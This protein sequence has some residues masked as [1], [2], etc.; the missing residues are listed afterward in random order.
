MSDDEMLDIERAIILDEENPIKNI[1]VKKKEIP[2]TN[3]LEGYIYGCS[4]G[5][6]VISAA[7][8]KIKIS[9]EILGNVRGL[10]PE[11]SPFNESEYIEYSIENYFIRSAGLY[12]RCLMFTG[13]VLNLGIA[14]ESI[15]HVLLVTN[16]HVKDNNLS[17][18]LKKIGKACREFST[19][20]NRIIHHGRYNDD[21]FTTVSVMHKANQLSASAGMDLPFTQAVIDH[22]TDKAIE[23]K[24][25]DFNDHLKKIEKTVSD[26]YDVALPVY[27]E[28]KKKLLRL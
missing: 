5:L 28:M 24:T 3:E 27:Y 16:E 1:D 19:D 4:Q 23:E 9:I 10:L 17:E 7:I 18:P 14:N 15:D 26:F 25:V 22:I 21:S 20:R 13:K 11:G 8:E 12:D 6:S 2:I